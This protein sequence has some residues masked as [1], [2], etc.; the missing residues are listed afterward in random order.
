MIPVERFAYSRSTLPEI[1]S[2]APF[3]GRRGCALSIGRHRDYP[4]RN[5]HGFGGQGLDRL[6]S[7]ERTSTNEDRRVLRASTSASMDARLGAYA[8]EERDRAGRTRRPH[9]QR[10]CVGE[11]VS[12]RLQQR[13]AQID[14]VSPLPPSTD[15]W[16]RVLR[17]LDQSKRVS[18]RPWLSS[19]RAT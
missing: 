14:G 16:Q 10:L 3:V 1:N 19:A 12:T 6:G 11:G 8:A 7:D 15:T 4:A 5:D 2:F 18:H 17:L 9:P 13:R